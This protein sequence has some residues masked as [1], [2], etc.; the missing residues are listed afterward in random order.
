LL[1]NDKVKIFIIGV[2]TE[3]SLGQL[4][5]ISSDPDSSFVVTYTSGDD[6]AL[7]ISSFKVTLRKG[8][9]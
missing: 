5:E 3:Y 4:R 9:N 1:T 6:L 2:G 7:A 8:G